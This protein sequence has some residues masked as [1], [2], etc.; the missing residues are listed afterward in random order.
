MK[1]AGKKLTIEFTKPQLRAVLHTLQLGEEYIEKKGI[2]APGYNEDYKGVF[3][4]LD[5]MYHDKGLCHDKKCDK[6]FGEKL[7]QAF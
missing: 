4:Y 5:K 6:H 3:D 2:I 7:R 1:K